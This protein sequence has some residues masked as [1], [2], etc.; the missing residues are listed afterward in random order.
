IDPGDTELKEGELISEERYREVRDQYGEGSFLAKMGAEAI[1]ELLRRIEVDEL[2]EE[3]RVVMRTE[4][5]Q[6]RRLKAAKRLKV[7][8]AFRRSGTRPEWMILDVIPVIPP[9]LRPLVPL[10]GG[11]F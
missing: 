8:D 5:S 1:K 9:E 3:L 7:V 2:A 4:T 11:R 6:I 10:D